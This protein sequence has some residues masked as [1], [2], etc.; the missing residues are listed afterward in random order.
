M[1]NELINIEWDNVICHIC[2]CDN[3]HPIEKDGRTLVEGQFGFAIHPV[4]CKGCGLIYLNPR[5]SKEDYNVFYTHYYDR[6]YRLETKDDYGK[7]A[8]IHNIAEI[9]DRIKSEIKAEEN[10]N[11][12]DVGCGYG[13]GLKYIQDQIPSANLFGIESSPDGIESLQSKEVGAVL[14]TDD[15]DKN[16]EDEYEG[17]MDLI[18]L[19]HVFEHLLNPIETLVK[20]KK[21]LKPTGKIYFAVPDMIDIRTDL[22]DYKYW[23]EYIFRSVHTY[24]YSKDTF[25]KTLEHGQLYPIQVG[26]INEEIW[27]LAGKEKKHEFQF[28]NMYEKQMDILEK[29][30]KEK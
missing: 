23:W 17:T 4:I 29:T 9:W 1:K 21:A 12:L 5:W 16:W 19:R 3:S 7:S 30:F 28:E 26:E 11:V 25:V 22:R 6:L 10:L 20:L 2:G 14:I 8:V 13:F 27:C 24:Y 15:F 18:I